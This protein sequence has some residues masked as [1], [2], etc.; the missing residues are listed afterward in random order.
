[1]S[2]FF[3]D[4]SGMNERIAGM[5][6]KPIPTHKVSF[7]GAR[8]YWDDE[9]GYLWGIN[10]FHDRLIVVAQW[11]HNT[12]SMVTETLVPTWEQPGFRFKVL[13]EYGKNESAPNE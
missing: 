5:N 13:E 9:S 1:M 10:P 12:L 3:V 8:C 7:W 11:F 4:G 6:G 2:A